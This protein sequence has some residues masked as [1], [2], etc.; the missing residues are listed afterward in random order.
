M[1]KRRLF[2]LVE[3]DDSCN[4]GT[5]KWRDVEESKN[6]TP[7]KIRTVGF[8]LAED[9]KRV[10]LTGSLHDEGDGDAYGNGCITIPRGCITKITRLKAHQRRTK[11]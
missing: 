9:K 7:G 5:Q 6:L 11:K 8:V 4:F 2:V 10:V 1:V 3:W